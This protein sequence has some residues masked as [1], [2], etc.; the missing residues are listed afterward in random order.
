MRT[1]LITAAAGLLAILSGCEALNS[2]TKF[3]MDYDKEFMIPAGVPADIPYDVP[4]PY[5]PTNSAQFFEDNNT[6]PDLVESC[7][8]EQMYAVITS[9]AG[10]DFSFVQTISIYL[11]AK[12]LPEIK[13]A[14]KENVNATDT[15]FLETGNDELKQYI[16]QDSIRLRVQLLTDEETQQELNTKVHGRFLVDAKIL[17][18]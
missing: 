17:G 8:L 12:Q 9:P 3:R 7:K 4:S 1:L 10:E 14:Y 5:F 6:S 16:L 11:G 2:L 15:L 13:V 18:I